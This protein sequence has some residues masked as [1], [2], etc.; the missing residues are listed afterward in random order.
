MTAFRVANILAGLLVGALAVPMVLGRVRPNPLYGLRTAAT[1]ADPEVWYPANRR[2]GWDLIGVGIVLMVWGAV[3]P[4][5]VPAGGP[6]LAL[7][8][9]AGA[10]GLA[11]AVAARGYLHA[12]HLWRE[13]HGDAP[14]PPA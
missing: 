2:S 10:V 5:L 1:L 12:R 6:R 7:V 8:S 9:A 13:R 4:A 3:G 14:P 11:L